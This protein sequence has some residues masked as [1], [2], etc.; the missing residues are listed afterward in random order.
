[1]ILALLTVFIY[2]HAG[3]DK[4]Q[5]EA[6]G[7]KWWIRGANTSLKQLRVSEAGTAGGVQGCPLV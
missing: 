2:E 6:E 7:Q 3:E 1:M 5:F 4:H